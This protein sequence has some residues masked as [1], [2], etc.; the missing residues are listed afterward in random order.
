MALFLCKH[1][2]LFLVAILA[3]SNPKKTWTYMNYLLSTSSVL[4][5]FEYILKTS[6]VLSTCRLMI[7]VMKQW[8]VW[9]VAG[10]REVRGSLESH[11]QDWILCF[12]LIPNLPIIKNKVIFLG[13]GYLGATTLE[14]SR[15]RR[16]SETLSCLGQW[17]LS[18]RRWSSLFRRILV[19]G[20]KAQA[21]EDKECE[22]LHHSR[23]LPEPSCGV[24]VLLPFR[25][26]LLLTRW[27]GGLKNPILFTFLSWKSGLSFLQYLN[28]CVPAEDLQ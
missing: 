18:L 12:V 14:D 2:S 22:Y 4:S 27:N 17:L 28:K 15:L 10:N 13:P 8:S 25:R 24:S 23:M 26:G 3:R 16:F 19:P 20:R 1:L 11:K 7:T 5:C 6:S 21:C 9:V